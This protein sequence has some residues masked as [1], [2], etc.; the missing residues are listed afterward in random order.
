MV[1]E[2]R[3]NITESEVSEAELREHIPL[4]NSVTAEAVLCE[5]FPSE[6]NGG[7]NILP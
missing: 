3:H 6:R 5:T 7:S 4:L 1:A 2:L